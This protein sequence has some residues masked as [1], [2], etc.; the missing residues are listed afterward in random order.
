[1]AIEIKSGQTLKSE[2]FKGLEFWNQLSGNIG[3]LLVYSGSEAQKRNSGI[4]VTPWQQLD[5]YL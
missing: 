5:S 4:S 1:L 3:G 2:A